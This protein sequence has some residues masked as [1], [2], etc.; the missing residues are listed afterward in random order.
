MVERNIARWVEGI[1][2]AISICRAVGGVTAG[3]LAGTMGG[4]IMSR[5]NETHK[6]E[7]G[8]KSLRFIFRKVLIACSDRHVFV[9]I[10]SYRSLGEEIQRA[11]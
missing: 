8:S 3:Q 9:K 10:E 7:K 2:R 1:Q 11:I 5:F 4:K 6:G